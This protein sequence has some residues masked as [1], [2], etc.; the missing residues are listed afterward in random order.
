MTHVAAIGTYLPCWG[1]AR[2]RVAGG[3]EDAVTLAVEA[4]RAAIDAADGGAQRVVLV[5]PELP[6]LW[7]GDAAGGCRSAGSCRCLR[8]A[9]RRCCWPGSGSIPRSRCQ[10]AS[11][12]RLPPST[13]SP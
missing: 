2:G 11:A 13:S 4:G 5:R 6:L 10:N 12:A 7:G 9:T 1:S 8:G 3:D